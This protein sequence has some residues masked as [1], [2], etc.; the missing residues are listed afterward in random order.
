[1][2]TGKSQSNR[3][4]DIIAERLFEAGYKYAFCFP[5]G[6]VLIATADPGA[7]NG[8]NVVANAH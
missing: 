1:M 6:E 5:G 4:A 8:V 7:V 3:A 2:Q